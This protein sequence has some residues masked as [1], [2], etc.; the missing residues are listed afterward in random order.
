MRIIRLL[1][2]TCL[3][4]VLLIGTPGFANPKNQDTI[5]FPETRHSVSGEFLAYFQSLPDPLLILGYPITE[6]FPDPMKPGITVQYFYRARLDYNP[7]APVGAQV[8]AAPLGT[9]LF[10]PN[11]GYE[12]A[13]I[14]INTGA[15][16]FFENGIPVCYAFLQFYDGQQGRIHFG[17]PIS[18]VL[19]I[20]G[21]YMQYFEKARLEWR[22]D[23]PPGFRVGLSDLGIIDF[24]Q[25][26]GDPRRREPPGDPNIPVQK[27]EKIR[28]HAF[29]GKPLLL[30]GQEQVIFVIVQDDYF[31][32]VA[33]AHV[34][35]TIA[36]PGNIQQNISPIPTNAEGFT[37]V[38]FN[39]GKLPPN[40]VIQVYVTAEIVNGAKTQGSTWFRTWW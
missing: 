22:P 33:N 28:L 14:P 29:V 2:F 21:R 15:C 27:L 1:I 36:L 39:S 35:I 38:R 18:V 3:V 24:D 13:D 31:R 9:L 11:A 5:W 25:R 7:A 4:G 23:M 17:A 37:E 40:Q 26:I 10:N 20:D 30:S 34:N 6:P 8:Q 32:P 19:E 16:R 12:P